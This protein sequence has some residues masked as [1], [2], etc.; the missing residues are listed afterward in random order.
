MHVKEDERNKALECDGLES[1]LIK[2]FRGN[3]E[4]M[5]EGQCIE[6]RLTIAFWVQVHGL[7]S[8][9]HYM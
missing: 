7:V 2:N 8:Y 4:L 1:S 6:V 3:E 9:Q 5:I